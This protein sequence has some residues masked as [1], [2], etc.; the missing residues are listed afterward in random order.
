MK[1]G[2]GPSSIICDGCGLPADPAHIAERVAR[3][4]LSTRYR[5]IRINV[6]FVTAAP[7]GPVKDD[8]YGPPES[9]EF[10]NSFLN[11]VGISASDDKDREATA[12]AAIA[13]SRLAELQRRGYYIS[14]LSECPI[15]AGEGRPDNLISRLAPTLL[16]RIRFNYKPKHIAILGR[17]LAPLV[18][19][20]EKDGL[21]ASFF[22]NFDAPSL[23]GLYRQQV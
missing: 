16:R 4:E 15:Q 6:L 22:E 10:F 20:V 3:L 18:D 21:S 9:E 13:A 12:P 23:V 14:Y 11:A 8:F 19:V 1:M 7:V 17:E 2:T 5:P